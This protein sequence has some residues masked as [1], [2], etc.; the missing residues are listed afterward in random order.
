MT[1]TLILPAEIYSRE[2]DARLLHGII[3]LTR[4]WRVIVGSKALINRAIWRLP[5]G[6]YLCQ[7]MTHK[8]RTM[9]RLLRSL[10][11][12]C[13]GWDE[14]GLIYLDRDVY[15]MRRVSLDSLKHLNSIVT[16]GK[17]G[18]DDVGFRSRAAGIEPLPLGNPRFDLVRRDLH[19]LYAAEVEAIKAKHGHFV[20]I[21]T[22]FSSFNPIISTHDLK[23]R[24]T[25][26]K[27]PPSEAELARF[28]KVLAHRKDVYERFIADL[29]A[30]A[31]ANPDLRFVLR[32]HPGEN[33]DIWR[34]AFD[35]LSN[36]AVSREGSSVPWL[37]AADALVH[38]SCT[39]AVEA[40]ILG[41]TP[42]CFCPVESLDDESA[43]PNPVS[44]RV[45]DFTE[46]QDAIERSAA[47]TLPMGPEQIEVLTRHVSAID[48]DL[49]STAIMKHFDE[50]DLSAMKPNH[51]ERGAIRLYALARHA[52]KSM[53]KDYITDRYLAKV[54]P[55]ITETDVKRRANDISDALGIGMAIEVKTISSNIFE[56]VPAR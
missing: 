21:N 4:G 51:L 5:R 43:L 45:Y 6:L 13:V 26:S 17:Q 31:R 33:E 42:I 47:G 2:F 52:Y 23:P 15:L 10:G 22:N 9:L 48:G 20:L 46:M 49:A 38:N 14:E 18:A 56:L 53:R 16:W 32:A 35:G 29:P 55:P 40:A 8:R 50:I 36:V 3:A 19:K 12:V 25:S 37:I 24:K 1:K 30:F 44:H 54:F 11:F 34:R 7:T 41:L 39:T 27:H 28:A